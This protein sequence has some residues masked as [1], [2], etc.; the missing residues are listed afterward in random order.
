MAYDSARGRL[1]LFGG[2]AFSLGGD[3]ADTWESDG[4][5]W[6][7]RTPGTSPPARHGHAMAYDS[8]RG[9]VVLFGG[10]YEDLQGNSQY[11]AD[12]WEWDGN[13]WVQRTPSGSPPARWGHAM[14]YDSARGR[15]VLFGGHYYDGTGRYLAD[16]WEWDGDNWVQQTP[17]TS[18]A[19]R[20]GHAMA[21]DSARGGVVLFGGFTSTSPPLLADTWEWDGDTWVQQT[22]A[23]G[24]AARYGHA[25]AYD[26]ARGRVVLFGGEPGTFSADTWEWDG[27]AW[28]Q[29]AT[30]P[31]S[32][33]GHAMAYDGA[34]G[35]VV[36][37][38]SR[39]GS[40]PLAETWEW[41]G[42]S[43][44]RRTSAT[45]PSSRTFH[46]MAYDSA[47]GRVVLFGGRES[48][49][50]RLA[51]TWEWDGNT[52]VQRTPATSP[53]ARY[54]HAMA[55]DG[56]RGRV[57][58]FGGFDGSNSLADTWEWDGDTWVQRTP[59][60][61]PPARRSHAMAYDGARERVVLFGGRGTTSADLADT[62][63]WDG[64]A[65]VQRRPAV[66]P[67]ARSS[68][69]MA[70]DSARG[71]V[72]IFGGNGRNTGPGY[73]TNVLNDT[74]EWDGNAWAQRMPATNPDVPSSLAPYMRTSFAM[75]YDSSRGLVVLFGGVLGRVLTITGNTAPRTRR[76]SPTPVRIR[77][78]NARAT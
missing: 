16:T 38:S 76:P 46:A 75:A 61:S 6:V 3:L 27:N 22:P 47:R 32:Q 15:V 53:L 24:P 45:S 59:A 52:W 36:L 65:W 4:A 56:A 64:N 30:S 31:G 39:A 71:R 42:N 60:T 44:V 48:T 20:Y 12:T 66:S 69:A 62:W 5:T 67:V 23:T 55:Y 8:A 74:W 73:S 7:Q 70:Y 28:V 21:Y 34:R 50:S 10:Y 25:M 51:D 13:T 78:W 57:V 33:T 14:A 77:F 9:R 29:N 37:V 43:W 63:E 72:V 54:L 26:S 40:L 18:P 19:A 1:V 11:F 68:F 17:A 35:R 2:L 58:L 41:D 49:G